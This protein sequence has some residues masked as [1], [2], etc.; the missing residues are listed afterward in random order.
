MTCQKPYLIGIHL[1]IAVYS[2]LPHYHTV[3]ARMA[4][5]ED[6]VKC[7][8]NETADWLHIGAARYQ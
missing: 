7:F 5:N 3:K 2:R 1:T 4:M 6:I 8:I